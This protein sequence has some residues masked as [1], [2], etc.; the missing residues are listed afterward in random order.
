[1]INF[2]YSN[3]S[4]TSGFTSFSFNTI[5]T[6]NINFNYPIDNYNIANNSLNNPFISG[7][8]GGLTGGLIGALIGT[9][10]PLMNNFSN[11]LNS[12]FSFPFNNNAQFNNNII[13]SPIN[14]MLLLSLL[15]LLLALVNNNNMR[16]FPGMNG[17][18]GMGGFPIMSVFPGIGGFPCIGG[19]PI[20]PNSGNVGFRNFIPQNQL[21]RI[22]LQAAQR[23]NLDP[24]Y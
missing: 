21:D 16:G 13:Q 11:P 10:I 3:F 4:I 17:F 22:I 6:S 1:M 8:I 12:P 18:P 20:T 14:P 9:A 15:L 2:N 7:L 5:T 24:L 19:F 23:Y